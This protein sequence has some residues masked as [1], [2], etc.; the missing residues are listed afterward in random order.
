MKSWI[1]DKN[2]WLS[3]FDIY[4]VIKDYEDKYKNFKFIGPSPI[5]F[6]TVLKYNTCVYDEICNF[7]L[8]KYI[9]NNIDNIGF[10]FNL[11][12]HYKS[13]SHWVALYLDC[14]KKIIYYFDSN[15]DLIPNE[16]KKLSNK[17]INQAK[18]MNINIKYKDNY[19]IVHQKGNTECGMYC[20]YFIISL[21]TSKHNFNYFNKKIVNDKYVEKFRKIYF[22]EPI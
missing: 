3:N 1:K 20:L 22:N 16:I 10:V 8:K 19:K 6:D 4:N 9:N 21:L 5:D 11:D 15:G 7:E 14:N 17:I 2:T 18:E 13:G 12:P